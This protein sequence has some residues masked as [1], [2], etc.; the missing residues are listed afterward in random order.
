[1][2]LSTSSLIYEWLVI[3]TVRSFISPLILTDSWDW[4]NRVEI[5]SCTFGQQFKLM[6]DLNL[7]PPLQADVSLT[8]CLISLVNS[9]NTS[10]LY[11]RRVNPIRGLL[12]TTPSMECLVG[13]YPTLV[14]LSTKH[15]YIDAYYLGFKILILLFTL[16]QWKKKANVHL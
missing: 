7:V 9:K 13:S 3:I 15:T 5:L 14:I 16:V 12:K 1:M 8:L 2:T 10:Y 6:T 11:I 4:S